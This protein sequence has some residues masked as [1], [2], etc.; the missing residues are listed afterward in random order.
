MAETHMMA[1]GAWHSSG[2]YLCMARCGSS[3]DHRIQELL[4]PENLQFVKFDI[5]AYT[6]QKFADA[7]DHAHD[8][9]ERT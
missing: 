6:L 2:G 7:F 9:V 1:Y 3:C 8:S 4:S 5:F